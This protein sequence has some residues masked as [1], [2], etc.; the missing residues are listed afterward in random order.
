MLGRAEKMEGV[1][2]CDDPGAYYS[3]ARL[4]V[5]GVHIRAREMNVYAASAMAISSLCLYS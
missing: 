1:W 2:V 5:S 3:C 4:D